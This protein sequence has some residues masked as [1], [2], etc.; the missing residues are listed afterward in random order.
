MYNSATK[1]QYLVTL[2]NPKVAKCYLNKVES[3]EE[4]LGKDLGE[5]N[6]EELKETLLS[7]K[8]TLQMGNSYYTFITHIK[9]YL[10]WYQTTCNKTEL[11]LTAFFKELSLEKEHLISYYKSF[12]EFLN[13]VYTKIYSNFADVPSNILRKNQKLF[14]S[15]YSI[16]LAAMVL[17]WLGLSLKEITELK[18]SDIEFNKNNVIIKG[19]KV[20]AEKTAVG[21]L[22]DI[23]EW[24]EFAFL[25]DGTIKIAEYEQSDYFIRR[26]KVFKPNRNGSGKV[27]EKYLSNRLYE[28]FNKEETC[29]RYAVIRENGMFVRAYNRM[30]QNNIVLKDRRIDDTELFNKLFDNWTREIPDKTFVNIKMRFKKFVEEMNQ[31]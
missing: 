6:A 10:N 26:Q 20:I 30:K 1:E 11:D 4:Q 8:E 15:K 22:R 25:I 21:V 5:F 7:I 29:F 18:N 14:L 19:E 28:D 16:S 2:P 27:S 3:W 23:S 17:S 13:D 24:G 12:D 9:K 31:E